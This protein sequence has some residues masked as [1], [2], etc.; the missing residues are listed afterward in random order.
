MT[1]VVL[2]QCETLGKGSKTQEKEKGHSR[3]KIEKNNC[4]V[5]KNN[6]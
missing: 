3:E 4:S 5:E 1:G 2:G 6:C